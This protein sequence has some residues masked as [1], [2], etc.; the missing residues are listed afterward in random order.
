MAACD[1]PVTAAELIERLVAERRP[2]VR[3]GATRALLA[4]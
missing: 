3:P 1:A 4:P 2:I